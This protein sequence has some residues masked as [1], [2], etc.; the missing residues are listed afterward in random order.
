VGARAPDPEGDGAYLAEYRVINR[1]DGITRWIEVTGHTTF[2]G[3]KAVRLVGTVQDITEDR[4]AQEALEEAD[5]RKDEFLATLAHE[6]RNPLSAIRTAMRTAEAAD[7]DPALVD[8]MTEII[9]RQSSHLERLIDDL[10]DVSRIS[11]GKVKLERKRVDLTGIVRQ[12]LADPLDACE[13]KGVGSSAVVP[14]RPI[15]IDAD[16]VRVAQ[17]LNNLRHNACKFTPEGGKVRV[18]VG[19]D[20]EEAVVSVSDTGLGLTP[21]QASGI[22][23][24]FT[25]FEGPMGGGTEGLGI[26][27][28][29]AKS[30]LEL[31]GGT[32][33]AKSEGPGKGSEF[34]VRLP[35][36]DPEAQDAEGAD[37]DEDVG[38]PARQSVGQRIVVAEDNSDALYVMAVMLRMKGHEVETA[39][40][41]AEAL[42]K[43]RAHRPDVALLDIG[44]P[45][46][47]GYEVARG[48]RREPW[49][50][51]MLL[52][53]MTGWG[54]DEDKRL[55][56]EAGFDMHLTKPVHVEELEEILRSPRVPRV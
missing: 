14:D 18:T 28:S 34:L 6:L 38:Q 43:V 55:A 21:E 49:G 39:A 20:G 54:R 25:Q 35:L 19:R 4:R 13:T 56:E 2:S 36:A 27:L 50:G 45:G 15:M 37:E 51:E 26:G 33:E 46:L 1:R 10:M 44:M 23:D 22:F 31:H 11:L 48:I 5:R 29:L 40:D 30:I 9:D 47:D 3:G 41:G 16:P 42:E 8:E 24:M 17:V 52:V 32:I 53:A 12:V 7:G